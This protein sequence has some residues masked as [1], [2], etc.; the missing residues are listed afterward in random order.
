MPQCTTD[1][2]AAHLWKRAVLWIRS[3]A[4]DCEE[5]LDFD[6]RVGDP[7]PGAI[8]EDSHAQGLGALDGD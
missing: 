8:E 5:L 7:R 3:P 4:I 2:A 1:A 6:E